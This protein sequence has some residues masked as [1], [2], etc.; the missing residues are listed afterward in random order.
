[1]AVSVDTNALTDLPSTKQWLGITTTSDDLLL[2]LLINRISARIERLTNRKFKARDWRFWLSAKNGN[3]LTIPQYPVIY[4]NRIAYGSE[5][6]L[7]VTYSGADIRATVQVYRDEEGST[8]GVRLVTYNSSGTRSTSELTAAS[9]ASTSALAT[10]ITAVSGWTGTADV[11]IPSPDLFPT[12]GQDADERT[13]ELNYPDSDE[14]DYRVDF[15]TGLVQLVKSSRFGSFSDTLIGGFQSYLVEARCGYETIPD[16]IEWVCHEL[17]AD[18]F[19]GRRVNR[20]LAS[21]SIG[22]YSYSLANRVQLTDDQMAI[23]AAYK[24]IPIGVT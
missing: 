2:T 4:L 18:A 1:M 12:A 19:S 14:D 23:L 3:E 20:N 21:E 16:D 13:V 7:S 11:N 9:N 15:D 10:A 22:D 6:A 5:T 24:D 17:I 8:G